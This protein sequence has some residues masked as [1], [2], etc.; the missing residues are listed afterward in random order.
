MPPAPFGKRCISTGRPRIA[1][2]ERLAR[3]EVV[4]DE[5]E[6]GLAPL[7]EEHL[8]R[9]RDARLAGRRPRARPRRMRS[10][11]ATVGAVERGPGSAVGCPHRHQGRR[12]PGRRAR[13]DL[14]STGAP[15]HSSSPRSP[16][17]CSPARAAGAE[18]SRRRHL[19]DH[20]GGRR[21]GGIGGRVDRRRQFHRGVHLGGRE[22]AA[23]RRWPRRHRPARRPPAPT[24]RRARASCTSAT[25]RRSA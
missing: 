9:A 7:R 19:A 14:A 18:L 3:R 10:P 5:V 16:P 11:A 24:T 6:L 12:Y 4:V 17:A 8:A 15:P 21:P 1:A 2:H 13:P 25:R 23:R 22:P 20:A